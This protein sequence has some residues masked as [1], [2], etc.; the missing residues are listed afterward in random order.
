[1]KH[2]LNNLTEEEKN[3]IR[4]QHTGGMNIVT[5]N[6]SRLIKTK[7]GDVKPLVNEREGE[8]FNDDESPIDCEHLF[9]SMDFIYD[10]YISQISLT[11]DEIDPTNLKKQIALKQKIKG[12]KNLPPFIG[13]IRLF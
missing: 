3:S 1:M 4:E 2:L 8:D 10:D 9:K 12:E 5:E 11:P 7:S 13:K 6:F